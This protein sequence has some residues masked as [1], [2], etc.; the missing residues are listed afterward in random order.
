M[1]FDCQA[2][3][4]DRALALPT[5]A[6]RTRQKQAPAVAAVLSR[7]GRL[8]LVRRPPTGLL[9][10]LWGLPSD[11]LVAGESARAGL[12]RL[13][14]DRLGVEHADFAPLGQLE[15]HFTHLRWQATLFRV[16]T[17]DDVSLAHYTDCAW[18]GQSH[19]SNY[20]LSRLAVKTLAVIDAATGG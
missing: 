6:P 1:A 17:G 5:T 13:L 10:G 9:G 11:R 12:V 18:V 7:G 4:Q 3:A 19:R 8:L 14:R 20:A 2:R 15:H 16:D